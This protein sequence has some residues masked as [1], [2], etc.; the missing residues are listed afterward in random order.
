MMHLSAFADEI[1][2]D[3]DDQIRVCRENGVT[4]V[5]L[6]SVNKINVLDFNKLLRQ[7][8]KSKLAAGGLRVLCIASPIGK[9]RIDEDWSRHFDRFKIAVEMAR[10][11]DAGLVRIFSY[12]APPGGTMTDFRQEVLRRMHAKVEYIAGIGVTLLH[13]NEKDIFGDTGA[14][15]LDLMKSIDSAQFRSA[16]D[17]ANFVQCGQDPQSIWPQLKPY[18]SHIHVKDA[19]QGT[20][21]VVPAGQGDGKLEPI[22]VDLNRSGYEG[23][24]SL[25]PHLSAAGKFGGF[26]GPQLF[27]EASDALKKLCRKNEIALA[28][29]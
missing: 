2:P 9:V 11:F 26:S 28:A 15:C 17:F 23:F 8:I 10:F 4:H 14:R 24:L 16:F 19:I 21:Q 1:S 5:E 12:Y 6:R 3:L 13:E 25:E 20:G 18:S 22:L 27:K 7:Q 29:A